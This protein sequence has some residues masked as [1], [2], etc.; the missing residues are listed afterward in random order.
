LLQLAGGDVYDGSHT[1]VRYQIYDNDDAIPGSD[2]QPCVARQRLD[3]F[4]NRL[5][6]SL[7]TRNTQPAF[8]TAAQGE[9]A[10]EARAGAGR[11]LRYAI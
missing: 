10:R 11:R 5:T 6:A 3:W 7:E 4:F 9:G 8:T 2:C 1:Y